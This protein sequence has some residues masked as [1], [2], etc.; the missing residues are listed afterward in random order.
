MYNHRMKGANMVTLSAKE[1]L[2]GRSLKLLLL[3]VLLGL[4]AVALFSG[5]SRIDLESIAVSPDEQYIACFET[6]NGHKIRCFNTDGSIAFIYDIP[7]DIS[8]GGHCT[9]WFEDDALCAFFYRTGKIVSFG[10]NGTMLG[11]SSETT[12]GSHP[13]YPSFARSSHQYI[14]DG[15]EIDVVYNKGNFLDYWFFGA[16]RYLAITPESGETKII[17]SWTAR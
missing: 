9:L 1:R 12:E 14:F 17:H 8:S 7:A 6:G 5:K 16:E 3:C 13:E 11:I 4:L 15:K 10:V 2:S